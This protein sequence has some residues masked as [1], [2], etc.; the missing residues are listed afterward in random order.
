VDLSRRPRLKCHPKM[1]AWE[2]LIGC[3][4]V[5]FIKSVHLSK[6]ILTCLILSFLITWKLT[7]TQ[8]LYEIWKI[9]DQ[10]SRVNRM[11]LWFF[12]HCTFPNLALELLGHW[13][14]MNGQL[15][16]IEGWFSFIVSPTAR[17]YCFHLFYYLRVSVTN[18][19]R[20]LSQQNNFFYFLWQS[21]MPMN[22]EFTILRINSFKWHWRMSPTNENQPL[23]W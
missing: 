20:W 9:S 17:E 15:F 5:C 4:F 16:N 22:Y 18:L 7:R 2:R 10:T 8:S 13:L 12:Y 23:H 6:Y 14:I 3:N 1:A 21:A 19:Y 11:V